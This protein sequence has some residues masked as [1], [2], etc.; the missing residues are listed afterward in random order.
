MV[1]KYLNLEE[2][3]RLLGITTDDLNRMRE[4]GEIRAFAE[5]GTWKFRQQ[6]VEAKADQLGNEDSSVL[7]GDLDIGDNVG[8]GTVVGSVRDY[9]DDSQESVTLSM[10]GDSAIIP[11]ANSPSDSSVLQE[12]PLATEPGTSRTYVGKANL[13]PSDSAVKLETAESRPVLDGMLEGGDRDMGT[14]L[15]SGTGLGLKG[16]TPAGGSKIRLETASSAS[17]SGLVLDG[18]LDVSP[19]GSG[20]GRTV[21][22]SHDEIR[23]SGSIG[24]Q[25]EVKTTDD[26]DDESEQV[27]LGGGVR[28]DDPGA[29][30]TIIGMPAAKAPSDSDVHVVVKGDQRDTINI[31]PNSRRPTDSD[32]R[33]V[34][35]ASEPTDSDVKLAPSGR[36]NPEET[37]S[38][39][40][41]A[42]L[43]LDDD[44]MSIDL[45]DTNAG[46][47]PDEEKTDATDSMGG[48]G[49]DEEE[50]ITL[51]LGNSGVIDGDDDLVLQSDAGGS[52]IT[53]SGS[54]SGLGGGGISGIGGN[55]GE[56]G[57]GMSAADSGLAL[58][59]P[60]NMGG[61]DSGSGVDL[62]ADDDDEFVLSSSGS[63]ITRR[64]GESGIGIGA[65]ESGIALA[66]LADSGISLETPLDLGSAA[67]VSG[68]T[69][70]GDFLL[71]PVDEDGGDDSE[72][73]GSQVIALDGDVGDFD[74]AAATMLGPEETG[75]TML[76]PEYEAA[77]QPQP[78][79]RGRQP[80]A[81]VG[82]MGGGMMP[83]QQMPFPQMATVPFT[84]LQ[85]TALVFCALFLILSG[86]MTFDLMANMWSWEQ[87]DPINHYTSGIMDWVINLIEK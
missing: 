79:A 12:P 62:E 40:D 1:Q 28:R 45:G 63:D 34:P 58:E 72:D 4:R 33:L 54:Q 37:M 20:I 35:S 22:G 64:P 51:D 5:G 48:S 21:L 50:D 13:T 24:K 87:S 18:D 73:S 76:E 42:D 17:D 84:G 80:V 10:P 83:M 31:S 36:S 60:L 19:G 53:I 70:G 52:D 47:L 61:S 46:A 66:S 11:G 16:P 81:P 82:A 38:L 43:A 41:A 8:A 78:Q 49:R 25:V 30:K 75:G 55:F 86:M 68:I 67:G 69:G 2:A 7:S 23:R 74:E 27:L 77:P 3:A 44:S 29:S 32:V 15:G 65:G 26:D 85:V 56:S 57:I 14:V 39:G 59:S 6:E 71:T 9:D